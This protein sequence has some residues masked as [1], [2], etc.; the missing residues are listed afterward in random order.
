MTES[1]KQPDYNDPETLKKLRARQRS[2]SVVMALGLFALC[3]LFYFITF[4]KMSN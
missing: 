1:F 2:R 3:V 4:V